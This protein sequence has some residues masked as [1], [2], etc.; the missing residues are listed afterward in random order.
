MGYCPEGL[1]E[2][3]ITERLRLSHDTIVVEEVSGL[4]DPHILFCK[5]PCTQHVRW[6]LPQHLLPTDHLWRQHSWVCDLEEG[7]GEARV[8]SRSRPVTECQSHRIQRNWRLLE[9]FASFRPREVSR[10]CFVSQPQVGEDLQF[11]TLLFC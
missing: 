11:N 10:C 8:P 5:V 2:S 4:Q 3:D 6:C 1:K 9:T 7:S